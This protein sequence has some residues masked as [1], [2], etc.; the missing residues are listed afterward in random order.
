MIDQSN[1]ANTLEKLVGEE[2]SLSNWA[3]FLW[4]K[5]KHTQ[6][7]KMHVIHLKHEEHKNAFRPGDV[8][9][10]VY[11]RSEK[12]RVQSYDAKRERYDVVYCDSGTCGFYSARKL[13]D[14][15]TKVSSTLQTRQE[16]LNLLPGMMYKNVKTGAY[17]FVETKPDANMR[18]LVNTDNGHR[19][20]SVDEFCDGDWRRVDLPY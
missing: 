18:V 2:A 3:A 15:Y 4:R 1:W 10:N 13:E 17:I 9:Q 19:T 12:V 7:K 16:N 6:V 8:L 14:E 11:R 5:R 20:M